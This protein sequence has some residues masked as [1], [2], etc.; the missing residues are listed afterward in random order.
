MVQKFQNQTIFIE[1]DLT[2]VGY[3]KKVVNYSWTNFNEFTSVKCP[4]FFSSVAKKN[5]AKIFSTLGPNTQEGGGA[6]NPIIA[7]NRLVLASAPYAPHES[8]FH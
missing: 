8:F 5:S 2:F 6:E 4:G 3:M 7:K 1:I